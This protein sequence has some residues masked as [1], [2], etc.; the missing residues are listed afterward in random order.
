[1]R[2]WIAIVATGLAACTAPSSTDVDDAPVYLALGDSIAFGYD[3]LTDPRTHEGYPELL[4]QRLGL[5]VTNASCPGEAT[6]G[7]LSPIGNDNGCRE[8]REAYP[9]HVAYEGAQLAFALDF[10]K[11]HDAT[12]LVTLDLGG[13][14]AS[15]L[16]DICA[17]DQ[18]CVLGAFFPMLEQYGKNLDLIFGEL[19]KVYDGPFVALGIYN[20]VAGDA[21]FAYGIERLNT[22][23]AEKAA[24]WDVR[25]ADGQAAFSARAADPCRGQLLIGM[26][27]GICDVHPSPQGDDALATAVE[28]VMS[29]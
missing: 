19:R 3:P 26:P 1:M 15:K 8:N 14:D 18:A 7:F 29:R 9:L 20:P 23:L 6:G 21:F 22:M 5:E 24:D 25:F 12:A 10:L 17:G 4:A 11:T 28:A 16:N 2:T 13:N 27:D